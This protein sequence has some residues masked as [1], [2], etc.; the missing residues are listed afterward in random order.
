LASGKATIGLTPAQ[1][2]AKSDCIFLCVGDT[3]MSREVIFGKDGLASA[4]RKG[5]IIVDCS[6]ISPT[7]SKQFAE[8]LRS[9]GI[10]FL[11]APGE[12]TPSAPVAK[13]PPLQHQDASPLHGAQRNALP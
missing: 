3:E 4:A 1:V 6:S 5:S 11:D 10:D 8:T 9:R 13:Y 7:T 12:A 2:A